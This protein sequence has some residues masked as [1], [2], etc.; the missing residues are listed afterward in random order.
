MNPA[1]C[2]P[3]ETLVV[4]PAEMTELVRGDEQRLI[5]RVA[6][7]LRDKSI[8]LDLR[9][10]DRIDAAG[11]AALISLY[12]TAR[13]QGNNFTVCN[14]SPRVEEILSL[15]GLAPILVSHNAVLASQCEARFERPA[16]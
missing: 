2:P 9:N 6:P 12:S 11:I 15:V 13:N 4:A 3:F 7:L 16:A 1:L 10:I 14:V 8:T 5:Q